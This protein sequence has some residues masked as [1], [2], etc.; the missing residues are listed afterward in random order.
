MR[1]QDKLTI[2]TGGSRGIGE[3]CVRVF[4]EAGAKVAFCSLDEPEG[5]RLEAEINAQGRGEAYFVRCDV[6][7]TDK[8]QDFI[9]QTVARYGRLDCLINNAGW[10][11][12]YKPIDQFSLDEF[13]ALLELNL[14]SLFAASK[15]ALPHLRQTRGN[16]INIAS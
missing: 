12:P 9:A 7:Q 11:P 14:V 16:I 10:H 8:L 4:V 15:F 5:R 3:G 2:V 6:T 1:Y 13:R